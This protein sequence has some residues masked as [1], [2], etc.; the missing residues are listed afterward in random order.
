ML[1]LSANA[2]G[3]AISAA[4]EME[5]HFPVVASKIQDEMPAPGVLARVPR[6]MMDREDFAHAFGIPK[7]A[8]AMLSAKQRLAPCAA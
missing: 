4:C 7:V 5:V 8:V 3:E 1:G 2:V 6:K